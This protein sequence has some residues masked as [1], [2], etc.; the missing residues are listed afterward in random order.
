MHIYLAA[1]HNGFELKNL[2]RDWLAGLGYTVTDIGPD[3]FDKTDDYPDF[4]IELARAV[5]QD[6]SKRVGIAVCGSGVGM[7]VA[8][9]KVRGVRAGLIHDPDIAAAARRDDN[10]NV[11]ALG[12]RYIT[13]P[14]AQQ[15]IQAWLGS[16]FAGAERHRR[17]IEKIRQYEE[18]RR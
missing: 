8:A 1:D 7:A 9:D 5:S 15:V 18:S 16:S 6:P 17:R 13:L 10:I 14:V 4:G 11:L 3:H 2:L 12:A